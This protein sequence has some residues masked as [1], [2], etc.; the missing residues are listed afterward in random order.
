MKRLALVF[1]LLLPGSASAAIV[2]GATVDGPS[3]DVVANS[4]VQ[5]DVAPDGTAAIAYLKADQVW[6]SRLVAGAWSVPQRVD[7]GFATPSTNP[8]IAVSNGGKVVVSFVNGG[9]VHARIK[10]SS[11]APFGSPA[12][13]SPGNYGQVDLAPNGNGYMAIQSGTDV[14]AR[15]LEGS[16]WTQ[17]NGGAALDATIGNDAGGSMLEAKAVT[18]ADGAGGVIA[19]GEDPGMG[20]ASIFARIITGVTVSPAAD[21]KLATLGGATAAALP[22]A[23]PDVGIDGPGTGWVVFRQ[24]F[25]Y[26]AN[27]RARAVV[28]P[29]PPG[30]AFGP[31]QVVDGLGATPAENVE[32]PRISVN[33]AGQGLTANYL[34]TTHG[35]QSA[36]LAG[37][38]WAP[39]IPVPPANS[40][41]AF[42]SPAIAA[43]GNGLVAWVHTPGGMTPQRI[44]GRT[45]LGGLGPVLGITDPALGALQHAQIF[46]AAGGSFAVVGYVQGDAATR[47]V[48]AAVVDLP[49]AGGGGGGGGNTD[50]TRPR[51]SRLKLSAKRFRLGTKRA[52]ASAVRTGTTIRYRLSEA[53]TVTLSFARARSGRRVR[54]RCVKPTRRNI[55]GRSCTRYVAV[56]PAL[57]FR[58]QAAGARRIRF[59]G[60]LSRRKSL[61]AAVYRM[62]LRARD[63]AGLR[64]APLRARVTILPRKRR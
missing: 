12:N 41:P 37:G 38:T 26:G 36:S 20:N 6:I 16:S 31:P 43:T 19:W 11:T 47:R 10:P 3:A 5:S 63:L 55:R 59:E 24:F 51:L 56:K 9:N 30:G 2:P 4:P 61:V 17:V 64:S 57:T 13:L 45:T 21:A 46:S 39:G 50:T 27:N 8:R 1:A 25:V 32:F 52:T 22:L 29:L 35:V 48:G 62:T 34:G 60:R 15:R 58:N 54:G 28:R 44:V 40:Q 23:M 33:A 49:G 53:S 42:A 18:R 14:I 7:E